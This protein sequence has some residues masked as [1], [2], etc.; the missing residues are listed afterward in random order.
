MDRFRRWRRCLRRRLRRIIPGM[1]FELGLAASVGA[2]ISM[3]FAEA[4]SD[5][6]SMTGGGR[7]FCGDC[8]RVDDVR[9]RDWAYDAVFDSEF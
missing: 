5:D 2:G 3:G 9:G 4:L 7:R 6:G 1:R 8:V